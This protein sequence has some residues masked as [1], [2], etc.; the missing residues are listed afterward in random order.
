MGFKLVRGPIVLY[1]DGEPCLFLGTGLGQV[2]QVIFILYTTMDYRGRFECFSYI[3]V[4]FTALD[5]KLV[6]T[7]VATQPN[8]CLKFIL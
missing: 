7:S 3:F 4:T 8:I 5:G 6:I 1:L 2:S